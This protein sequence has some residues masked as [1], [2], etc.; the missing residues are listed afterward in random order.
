MFRCFAFALFLAGCTKARPLALP[1]AREVSLYK[2]GVVAASGSRTVTGVYTVRAVPKGRNTF[3]FVTEHGE[4][5]WEEGS[6]GLTW[7]SASPKRIDP[8]PL[9]LQHA[10]STVPAEIEVDE[11]GRLLALRSPE[12]WSRAAR[13]AIESTD[14]PPQAR[15]SAEALVDPDGVVRDLRRSFPGRPA[16][17]A[18]WERTETLAGLEVTRIETCAE[19]QQDRRTTWSCEG[20]L[21]GPTDGNARLVDGTSRTVVVVDARGLVE[22]T[23]AYTGTLVV[24][25]PDGRQALDR[26]IAGK[27]MV[28]RQGG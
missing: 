7:D 25:S 24:L 3:A 28:V 27:R 9:T 2:V 12:A 4:G 1:D 21:Q 18:S 26:P 5:T 23:A 19:S 15:A 10:I 11:S 22:M 8:W 13:A 6:A 14:V 20:T 16:T 17:G